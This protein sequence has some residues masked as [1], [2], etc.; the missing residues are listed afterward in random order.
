MR[1]AIEVCNGKPTPCGYVGKRKDRL[2]AWPV[3]KKLD[4]AEKFV[5]EAEALPC[6]RRYKNYLK[7]R[8]P[9]TFSEYSLRI[10]GC[11]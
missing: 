10:T 4:E 5:D 1:Y 9:S 7:K 3:K 2:S 11:E 6:M 8:Y